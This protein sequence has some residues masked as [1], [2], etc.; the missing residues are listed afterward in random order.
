MK[1]Y[2]RYKDLC[3]I[4]VWL[5]LVWPAHAEV[6]RTGDEPWYQRPTADM[7]HAREL[8]DQA[9]AKHLQ[10]LRG[11][12]KELYDRALAIWDN[13]DIRWNLSLVLEDLGEYLRAHKELERAD[14]WG[15]ALGADRLHAVRA[16]MDALEALRLGR[17]E[18]TCD[19]P[20]TDVTLDGQPWF[21]GGAGK[22]SSLV[23]PGQHFIVA[24]KTGFFTIT[25]TVS[26]AAGQIARMDFPMDEDHLVEYRRWSA[27]KPWA[28]VSAAAVIAA[29]GAV[30]EGAAITHRNSAKK[31]IPDTASTSAG[32][33]PTPSPRLYLRA[34]SE[35]RLA[36]G[37]FAA[38]GITAIAGITLLWFN[39]LHVHRSEARTLGPIEVTPFLSTNQAGISA[40][41]QF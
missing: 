34:V 29:T 39:Q 4:L 40:Q 22:Q 1:R 32:S 41:R 36:I 6:T 16:R 17:L 15:D 19:E 28:V 37:A 9:V 27:W 24:H 3:A 25:R 10:L 13:P 33:P 38:S 5:L 14:R 18:A 30:L 8:F 23:L 12:A 35:N 7:E 11:D 2:I 31:L 26:V 21:Q 20:A